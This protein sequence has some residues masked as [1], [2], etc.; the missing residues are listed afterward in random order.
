LSIYAWYEA[1]KEY[2]SK[3]LCI[4]KNKPQLKCCGKCYLN[5]QLKKVDGNSGTGK[6]LPN[7]MDKF[8]FASY[9]IPQRYTLSYSIPIPSQPMNGQYLLGLEH[10]VS[11]SFFHPP[12]VC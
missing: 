12:C 2:V 4:N 8:E 9:V 5:K 6:T 10:S 11:H 3:N 1:N 7:K